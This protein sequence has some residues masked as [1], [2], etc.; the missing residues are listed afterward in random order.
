MSANPLVVATQDSTNWSTGLGLVE[1]AYQITTGIQNDSWV[2]VTLGG[3]GGAL[4]LLSAALDPLGA[5]VSW[6]VGWLMEH[7]KPLKEALDWLAGNA[8]AVAAQ[9]ATWSNVSKFTDSARAEYA[10]RLGSEV[11][12][13]FG[14][15]GDAYREH[16]S[17][18]L[19]ALE[20]IATSSQGISYAVQGAGLL[21][22]L[23]RGI[24]RDLIAD[25]VATL[26]VRLPEWLAEEGLT[27][28]L[29]TPVVI[30]QVSSLVAKWVA[31]IEHFVRGLLNSLKRL[32][33]M[34][35]KLGEILTSLKNKLPRA[36]KAVDA[37]P[38]APKV[39][40]DYTFNM[41]ENPGPLADLGGTPAAN[42][43][44]GRYDEVTL[45][46]NRVLFRAGD[47]TNPLGQW[48]TTDPPDSVAHVRIDSAVKA[49]WVDPQTQLLT[50]V[51]DINTVYAVEIPAGTKVYPGP[52]GN[53]GGVY[54]GGGNQ[55]F[56]PTPWEI[57]PK[58]K[59]VGSEPL[60]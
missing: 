33:P 21:V 32:S 6:G 55:I 25:F 20:G 36:A 50:G 31:K 24:V 14:A 54:V 60:P 7:V 44:G 29:A 5:L 13:W 57:R 16:A 2:D 12:G 11:S 35:D 40:G 18:H 53:M 59:V 22:G 23:V 39:P 4:D 30:G 38:L 26:A 45:P 51:S 47:E 1:D 46:E 3:V 8:D 41:V 48:F 27:L 19:T 28:G 43:A 10:S 58:V 15:S 17:A 9:A 34:I 37:D 42:Y 56:I 49:Q 52:V